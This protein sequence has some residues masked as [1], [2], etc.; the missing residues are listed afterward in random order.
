MSPT[1]RSGP[2]PDACHS[3]VT[4][5]RN[6]RDTGGHARTRRRAK[7]STG[8]HWRNRRDTRGHDI[9][10]VRDREPRVPGPPE[11]MHQRPQARVVPSVGLKR[12]YSWPGLSG[13]VAVVWLH[14][15]RCVFDEGDVISPPGVGVKERAGIAESWCEPGWQRASARSSEQSR[16]VRRPDLP[17]Q[18]YGIS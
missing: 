17:K 18:R 12:C 14:A 9:R 4:H 6:R 15:S 8:G 10:R 2:L 13:P 16:I 5:S 7:L 11:D 1:T 3:R